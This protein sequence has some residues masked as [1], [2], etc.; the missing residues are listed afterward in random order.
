MVARE[1]T[2][3]ARKAAWLRSARS[4]LF[5][6]GMKTLIRFFVAVAV[7]CCT[8]A[9]LGAASSGF[10]SDLVA[11][12]SVPAVVAPADAASAVELAL[13]P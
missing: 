13:I 7:S 2:G 5:G 3:S 1:R 4:V 12:A 9:G 6:L 8:F 10:R 11:V